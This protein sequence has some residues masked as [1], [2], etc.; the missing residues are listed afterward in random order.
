MKSDLFAT[1]IFDHPRDATFQGC[2]KAICDTVEKL[3]GQCIEVRET[4]FKFERNRVRFY[5][6]IYTQQSEFDS[7]NKPI[8]DEDEFASYIEDRLIE[9]QLTCTCTILPDMINSEIE[10]KR[11][12]ELA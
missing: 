1:L 6:E 5:V 8:T 12:M 2:N 7:L 4:R 9:G 3:D 10:E 11:E